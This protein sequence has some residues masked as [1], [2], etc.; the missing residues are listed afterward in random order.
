MTRNRPMNLTRGLPA[1]LAI[2][3]LACGIAA[4]AAG[5]GAARPARKLPVLLDTDIGD[6][7]DD[8]W[9]LVLLLKSPQLDLKLVTTTFGKSEYRAKIIA[10]ILTVAGRTDV[11]IGLGA[12]GTAG[13]GRQETWIEAF[14]LAD[15]K[16]KVH[17][18]GV[19]ALI[20]TVNQSPEPITIIS[21]GPSST[22][23]AAL[24]KD[25]GIAAKAR[26]AGMQGSVRRGYGAGSKPCPEWNVQAVVPAAQR[27]LSAPWKQAVITPLDTCGLVNLD[28]QRFQ[29]L[30]DSHDPLVKALLDSSRA[31]AK[32]DRATAS[33][34]LFDTVAVYLALPGPRPLLEL[35]HLKIEVTTDAMT[36][37]DPAGAPM[38][39]ATRWKDLDGYRDLLVNTLLSK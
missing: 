27:V 29:K 11:P 25:P 19:Q 9:A 10:K 39:V 5:G 17:D 6:H 12:G 30:V 24:E 16:G 18:D 13:S 22:V 31:W 28:G 4:W 38:Q 8:T 34:T 21:I 26:F 33:N 36:V 32:N 1:G 15:Y 7:A 2:L 3:V 35:E 20:D 14:H 37:I 23:A